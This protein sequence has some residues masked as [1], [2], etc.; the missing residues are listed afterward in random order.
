[1]IVLHFSL[2]QLLTI[3]HPNYIVCHFSENILLN[4]ARIQIS[5]VF[6]SFYSNSIK[7]NKLS[8]ALDEQDMKMAR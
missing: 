4:K 1:M 6:N 3:Y 7:K 8:L 5:N 2:R